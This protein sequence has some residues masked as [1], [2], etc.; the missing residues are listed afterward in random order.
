M[1]GQG[2]SGFLQG[3]NAPKEYKK[4]PRSPRKLYRSE[5]KIRSTINKKKI[6]KLKLWSVFLFCFFGSGYI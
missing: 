2:R 6:F 5:K 4:I 3:G 1:G